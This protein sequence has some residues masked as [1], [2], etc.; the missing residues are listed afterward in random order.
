[1][2]GFEGTDFT[3]EE[4]IQFMSAFY[5]KYILSIFNTKE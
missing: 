3:R 4:Q 1:M 2:C 5:A